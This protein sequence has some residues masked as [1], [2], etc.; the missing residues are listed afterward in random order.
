VTLSDT[1]AAALIAAGAALVGVLVGVLLEY[2]RER[3]DRRA[4]LVGRQQVL[5][6]L[7]R[8]SL[9]Q[10]LDAAVAWV[11]AIGALVGFTSRQKPPGYGPLEA[12]FSARQAF[13]KMPPRIRSE[14]VQEA[15]FDFLHKG[16]DTVRDLTPQRND[17]LVMAQNRLL[18]VIQ[19]E[20]ARYL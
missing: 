3:A 7:Q 18:E 6:D 20:L 5:D 13:S 16:M 1:V 17:E 15:A 10:T 9:L 19:S 14:V 8:E 12:E 11:G 4:R 2:L